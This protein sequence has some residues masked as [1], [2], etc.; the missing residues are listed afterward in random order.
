MKTVETLLLSCLKMG[1]INKMLR[2][3]WIAIHIRKIYRIR[4]RSKEECCGRDPWPKFP[5]SPTRTNRG[6]YQNKTKRKEYWRSGHKP[7]R[8]IQR[9]QSAL[10]SAPII[11]CGDLIFIYPSFFSIYARGRNCHV[12]L[13]VI[14]LEVTEETVCWM[15]GATYGRI[16]G[17]IVGFYFCQCYDGIFLLFFSFC[18]NEDSFWSLHHFK[19]FAVFIVSTSCLINLICP[20]FHPS[21]YLPIAA[22]FSLLSELPSPVFSPSRSPPSFSPTSTSSFFLDSH[23]FHSSLKHSWHYSWLTYRYCTL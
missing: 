5:T 16:W 4:S 21:K 2:L 1:I 23:F 18:S 8:S 10:S 14:K 6:C 19:Y 15:I 3:I 9:V 11:D 22:S 17:K 13:V 12:I 7:K 20:F